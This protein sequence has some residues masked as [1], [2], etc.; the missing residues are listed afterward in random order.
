MKREKKK[1][2]RSKTMK[3]ELLKKLHTA[4][5]NDNEHQCNRLDNYIHTDEYLTAE[6]VQVVNEI[7]AEETKELKEENKRLKRIEEDYYDFLQKKN[8]EDW[9][10]DNVVGCLNLRIE[11]K[12]KQI[13]ELTL[14]ISGLESACDAYNYSQRTYQ[15]EIKELKAQI[16]QMKCCG[17]C[18]KYN[19][20][21]GETPCKISASAIG[22][23]WE[24]SIGKF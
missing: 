10:G 3:E 13:E 4:M 21:Y 14:K 6:V 18:A 11:Q 2:I 7:V 9:K 8:E 15:E 12:D 19:S 1:K 17:N 22:G 16:E 24:T 20:G 23:E 5:C